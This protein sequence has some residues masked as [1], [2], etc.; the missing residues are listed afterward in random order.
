MIE[1]KNVVDITSNISTSPY[2]PGPGTGDLNYVYTQAIASGMW[3]VTHNLGKYPSVTVVDSGGTT[4]MPNE[5]NYDS[6]NKVT[7]KFLAQFTGKAY[8]N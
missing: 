8:L 4:I 7:I 3:E 5:V 1:N 6:N 2:P